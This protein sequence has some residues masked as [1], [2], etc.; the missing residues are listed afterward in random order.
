VR[1]GALVC[2]RLGGVVGQTGFEMIRA[3]AVAVGLLTLGTVGA[4]AQT[5]LQPF[6]TLSEDLSEQRRSVAIRIERRLDEAELLRIAE[7]T[8]NHGKRTYARTQINYFLPGSPLNQGAWASVLFAPDAKVMVHGL[9]REDEELLLTEHRAD[10]R[11]LLGAWLT[12]PPAAPGRL[13]IYSDH[14]RIFAEWRL[15]NG[16]KTLDELQ[17]TTVKSGR[18]FDIQGGGYYI[19]AK[20]G[21]LE[22]WDKTT[23]IAVGERIRPEHLAL[24]VAVAIGPK[25]P[26]VITMAPARPA[27]P[28]EMVASPAQP[29]PST[30][31]AVAAVAPSPHP[32]TASAALT[33]AVAPAEADLNTR[34]GRPKKAARAKSRP[35]GDQQ[36][37]RTAAKAS[38]GGLTTGDQIAAKISGRY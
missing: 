26:P 9:R 22:I 16:Q 23:L 25:V 4:A 35:T 2:V 5:H 10:K 11:M 7:H 13:S 36:N 21:E 24:P 6:N 19:L 15:R 32:T 14:G 17:D 31:A 27:P 12:Q 34:K 20:S 1:L 8:R 38:K 33:T 37:A 28:V 30:A 3:L 18:R 29:E